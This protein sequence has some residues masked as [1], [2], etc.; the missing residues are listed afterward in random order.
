MGM[1]KGQRNQQTSRAGEYYVA[2][3]LSRRG[4]YAVTF[5]GNM[6]K[7]DMVAGNSDNT[8]MVNIQ[9][10]T[11]R[12]DSWQTSID[13]GIPHDKP[14]I[15][16]TSFWILVDIG[17]SEEHPEYWIIPEW[18]ISNDIYKTHQAYLSKHGGQRVRSPKSKHHAIT[19]TR[20]AQWKNRWDV[21][22]LF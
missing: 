1:T 6:P 22:G 11:K 2:A 14:R 9:V 12:S 4:A 3:E 18:W 17:N 8:R 10:K 20:I 15:P 5:A 21:L 13:E 19:E 7:I 16:E